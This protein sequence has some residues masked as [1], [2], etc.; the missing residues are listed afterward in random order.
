VVIQTFRW[1][2]KSEKLVVTP[3]R[4]GLKVWV[5]NFGFRH[6]HRQFP[7]RSMEV[8]SNGTTM[9]GFRRWSQ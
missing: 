9:T 8:G 3:G 5:A 7:A 2:G 4:V 6:H 1:C